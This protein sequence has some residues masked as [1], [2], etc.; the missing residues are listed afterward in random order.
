MPD[1]Q[2]KLKVLI[3]D[4]EPFNVM[5]LTEVLKNNSYDIVTASNGSAALEMVHSSLPDIILLD[6][7]MPILDGFEVCRQLKNDDK[8]KHIPIIFISSLNDTYNIVRALE[9]GAVDFITKPFQFE[10]VN[11]RVKTHLTLFTQ[12]QKIIYLK[13]ELEKYTEQLKN[14]STH[15]QNLR[16][17]EKLMVANKVH[18]SIGQVLIAMKINLGL[19]KKN[20]R[21]ELNPEVYSKIEEK[22]SL[23]GDIVDD[24]INNVRA[25]VS[26]LKSDHLELLG[27]VET[28]QLHCIE[29]HLLHNI[30]CT[31][32][33]QGAPLQIAEQ[34][35]IAVYR[36]FEEA[37]TNIVK[38]AKCTDVKVDLNYQA[39]QLT[40]A[41]RD[42][43]VGFDPEMIEA[44]KQFGI[45]GMAERAQFLN[46]DFN[47]QSAPNSGTLVS[48]QF[49]VENS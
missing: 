29:F 41:I 22:Y 31:C 19:W 40:L 33:Y 23:L 21:Q 45:L 17:E 7:M 27:L 1:S 9:V 4:D 26:Q 32:N 48:L 2:S 8:Y 36:I 6:I 3:V 43:G 28:I 12:N 35:K 15:L 16:E 42:N 39:P 18:D 30:P 25:I 46:A 11:A 34:Q 13:N 5:L 38:H 49:T 14:F 24:T 37:L 20:V 47:I 44:D 10:E